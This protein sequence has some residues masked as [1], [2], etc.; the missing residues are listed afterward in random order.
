[1]KKDN[2]IELPVSQMSVGELE[3]RF[4][5]FARQAKSLC[6]TILVDGKP[7]P[8]SSVGAFFEQMA[9]GLNDPETTRLRNEFMDKVSKNDPVA[10][11]QFCALRLET[12]R[13][14]LYAQMEWINMWFETVELAADERP[15][16]QNTFDQEVKCFYVG[17]DG[18]PKNQKVFKDDVEV[19]LPLRVLSTPII[20]YKVVDLYRGNIVDQA[21]KTLHLSR[22]MANKQE[23]EARDLVF[24][25][26]FGVFVFTG[27]RATWPYVANSYINTD[28]LPTT[29]DVAVPGANGY[30]DWP[31][32]DA[33]IDYA[34]RFNGVLAG[35]EQL[36]FKPTGVIRVPSS[37]PRYFGTFAP[38]SKVPFS[39][40]PTSPLANVAE[41]E[42]QGKGWQTVSYKGVKWTIVPDATLDPNVNKCYPEFS[43]K[44][45]R[46]YRKPSLDAEFLRTGAQDKDLFAAN[47]EERG[48][49]SVFSAYFNSAR[50]IY[51]ARFGYDATF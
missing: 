27:K 26:A 7:Q 37:H 35:D 2:V 12:Y 5:Y 25:N 22:D 31:V 32:L 3:A 45:G 1:M 48:M 46:V 29:N 21:L 40:L 17:Q 34:A 9:S 41:Q 19:A 14:T 30:F 39:A 11:Q 6:G 28:N 51:F 20:R 47:E 10:R 50:R 16:V 13:N 4:R 36:T 33:I 43:I 24:N 42:V 38:Q 8:A 18:R 49:K 23:A 44:P 15:I